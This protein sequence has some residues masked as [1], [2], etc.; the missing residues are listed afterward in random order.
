MSDEDAIRQLEA[1]VKDLDER[2]RAS[3]EAVAAMARALE[4]VRNQVI[5]TANAVGIVSAMLAVYLDK[6]GV[7]T[8]G[9]FAATLR[10]SADEAEQTAPVHMQRPNRLDL[11]VLRTI[12]S[13]L[14]GP[15]PL[16]EP[17]VIDGGA[18]GGDP[19]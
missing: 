17:T 2:D 15:V 14:D 13:H 5:E 9:E 4:G 11:A 1:A 12:A 8:K 3:L 7:L 19:A 18:P 6:A 16:W 10:R